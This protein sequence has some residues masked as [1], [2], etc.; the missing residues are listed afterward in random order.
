MEG[1]FQFCLEWKVTEKIDQVAK[2]IIWDIKKEKVF[3][4]DIDTKVNTDAVAKKHAD[5]S[6]NVLE[7]TRLINY[8]TRRPTRTIKLVT[9]KDSVE[10]ILKLNIRISNR[11]VKVEKNRN[12][13]VV[14]CYNCQAFGHIS[15]N[16]HSNQSRCVVCGDNHNQVPQCN[17]EAKCANCKGNHSAAD[18]NCPV[19]RKHADTAEQH[20]V[21]KH[22]PAAVETSGFEERNRR[23][24]S[25]RSVETQR[26]N[27][28]VQFSNANY[29]DPR[30]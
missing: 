15:I 19:Y 4:K 9:D 22:V 30:G 3:L 26:A 1:S 29:Q 8:S 10:K 21:D 16:C 6:I 23:G 27:R 13:N 20:S 12:I 11:L 18:L 2:V 28:D 24:S 17:R 25:S 5:K 14:R 7:I